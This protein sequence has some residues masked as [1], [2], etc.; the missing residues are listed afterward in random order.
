MFQSFPLGDRSS[1]NLRGEYHVENVTI[2]EDLPAKAETHQD[3]AMDIDK[4]EEGISVTKE[5]ISSTTGNGSATDHAVTADKA[6]KSTQEEPQGGTSEL[7]TL[8]PIF[9]S[10]QESFSMP[11]RLFDTNHFQVFKDGLDLTIRK[12]QSVHQEL[13]ARGTSRQL[14][15][16]KRPTKRKRNSLDEEVSNSINPRYLTSRDLFDL[17]VSKYLFVLSFDHLTY[18][19]SAILHFADTYLCRR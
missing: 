6:T 7:D 19:R 15:E 13:Q 5:D 1:V 11:T 8:Y 9:W 16:S 10:L 18:I 17:E 14:D 12:F 4:Q 3:V 2:F